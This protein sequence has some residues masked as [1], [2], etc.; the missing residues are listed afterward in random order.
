MSFESM[1]TL[2]QNLTYN[3]QT[4]VFTW[5]SSPA[6]RVQANAVAGRISGSGYVQ[7]PYKRK[8]FV[9]HRLAWLLKKGTLP[10]GQIDHINGIRDDNRIENLRD[11]SQSMNQQNSKLRS[12]NAS[13]KKGVSWHKATSKWMASICV[14]NKRKHLGVFD[15]LDEAANAYMLAAKDFHQIN[16]VFNEARS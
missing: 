10:I 4:G 9:A 16:S 3:E 14:N 7:I 8:Y 12:D 15:C 1:Q 6:L 13:G 2:L 5:K 11:V